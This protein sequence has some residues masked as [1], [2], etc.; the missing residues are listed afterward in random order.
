MVIALCP[1]MTAMKVV[2]AYVKVW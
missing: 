2:F 1:D